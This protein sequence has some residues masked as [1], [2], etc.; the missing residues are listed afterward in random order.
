MFQVAACIA[1]RVSGAAALFKVIVSSSLDFFFDCNVVFIL[2]S[3]IF[4]QSLCV[5]LTK[6]NHHAIQSSEHDCSNFRWRSV[7]L[8]AGGRDSQLQSKFQL[9][10]QNRWQQARILVTNSRCQASW[11]VDNS[12]AVSSVNASLPVTR[13]SAPQGNCCQAVC[14][15]CT[16]IRQV[17]QV[18]H[19][20]HTGV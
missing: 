11:T 19:N 8:R 18:F 1:E 17:I 13:L 5:F 2:S 14:L 4:T 15:S 6:Q 16:T 12:P 9:V 3:V 7:L 10:S 20:S